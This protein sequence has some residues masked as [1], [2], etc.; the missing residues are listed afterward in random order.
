MLN[1]N[2]INNTLKVN[3]LHSKLKLKF[4]YTINFIIY[5]F[6]LKLK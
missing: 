4:S 1:K 5:N 2:Y 3:Y 6:E